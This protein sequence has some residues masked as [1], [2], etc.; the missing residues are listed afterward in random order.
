MSRKKDPILTGTALLT[1]SAI[2]VK[3]IGAGFKIPLAN[4]LGGVG[5]S[6]FA[7]AYD[8]FSP[9][10]TIAVTG[11]CIASSRLTA[12]S[13]ASHDGLEGAVFS[14]SRKCFFTVGFLSSVLLILFCRPVAAALGNEGA[15]LPLAVIAPALLFGCLASAYRGYFQGRS[16]MAPTAKA[17]VV[18][19]LFKLVFGIAGA[20]LVFRYLDSGY[21]SGTAPLWLLSR[22]ERKARLLILQLSAAGGVFGVTAGSLAGFLFLR[23]EYR[24]EGKLLCREKSAPGVFA[25]LLR[26]ALPIAATSAAAN[27]ASLSDLSSVMNGLRRAVTENPAVFLQQ[28]AGL[29]PPEVS[30]MEIPE[31]LYGCY[32][33]LC[34]SLFNLAPALSAGIG[35]SAVPV[36]S[37]LCKKKNAGDDIKQSL[38]SVLRTTAVIAFP[39]GLGISSAPE[40]ILRFLYPEKTMEA[41]IAV[42]LLRAMGLISVLT[43]LSSVLGNV[44]QAL[45]KEKIPLI[46]MITGGC[47]KLAVNYIL[48]S[49]PRFNIRGVLFGTGACYLVTLTFAAAALLKSGFRARNFS[50]L[51]FPAEASL[52]CVIIVRKLSRALL[53]ALGFP[54]AFILSAAVA[55]GI[56]LLM[57][58]SSIFFKK[59]ENI[60]CFLRG[61]T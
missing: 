36:L 54:A 60:L 19:A 42:P 31:Y 59:R 7:T 40:E 16:R 43:A 1:G 12:E 47:M 11:L 2:L 4:I 28:Y 51:L 14:A 15:G 57:T 56:Y 41:M 25:K 29:T 52:I 32:S 13:L 37:A 44:L 55:G 17:Q 35:L 6:Y 9:L 58:V 61:K 24:R 45:G 38:R 20:L 22:D 33:G 8:I 5:M 30:L 34:M 18:E 21:E 27:L 49:D 3:I 10:Y 50:V 53:P 23:R 46:A 48:V 26:T 39:L